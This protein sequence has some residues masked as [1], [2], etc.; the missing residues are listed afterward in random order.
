V[1]PAGGPPFTAVTDELSSGATSPQGLERTGDLLYVAAALPNTDSEAR[2]PA[3]LR[4]TPTWGR[5]SSF[6]DGG[7]VEL[8]GQ[9]EV[10]S[11]I[12]VAVQSDGRVIAAAIDAGEIVL[13]R[14]WD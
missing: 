11:S 6:A 12:D 13:C 5:D 8:A 7:L 1:R 10:G 9:V 4:F 14:V 3:V 2:A